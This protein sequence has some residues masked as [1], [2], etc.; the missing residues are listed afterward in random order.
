MPENFLVKATS[1][2]HVP[3]RQTRITTHVATADSL[4]FPSEERAYAEQRNHS[5][6]PEHSTGTQTTHC[7]HGTANPSDTILQQGNGKETACT[8]Y[9]CTSV[10]LYSKNATIESKARAQEASVVKA[11]N[12]WDIGDITLPPG[13]V[14]HPH[15]QGSSNRRNVTGRSTQPNGTIRHGGALGCS[16]LVPTW[17]QQQQQPQAARWAQAGAPTKQV[18]NPANAKAKVTQPEKARDSAHPEIKYSPSRPLRLRASSP[19]RPF[20]VREPRS[21][22]LD[23]EARM[24]RRW[25]PLQD[26]AQ[27]G[28]RAGQGQGNRISA[29]GLTDGLPLSGEK[30]KDTLGLV[31]VFACDCRDKKCP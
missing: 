15:L 31:E 20:S 21:R 7:V 10:T 4:D 30:T 1:K 16:G 28:A 24:P 23:F 29:P 3:T 9:Y 8:L 18:H 19:F 2:P 25:P 6:K 12:E 22:A 5:I 27:K 17:M 13:L 26:A 11:S 14:T